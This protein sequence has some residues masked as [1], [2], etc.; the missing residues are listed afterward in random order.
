MYQIHRKVLAI[1]F[2]VLVAIASIYV[3][4]FVRTEH[5]QQREQFISATYSAAQ[6]E[7]AVYRNIATAWKA[8]TTWTPAWLSLRVPTLKDVAILDNPLFQ[9]SEPSKPIQQQAD[10]KE[11]KQRQMKTATFFKQCQQQQ[12]LW[13]SSSLSHRRKQHHSQDEEIVVH[14]DI[15]PIASFVVNQQLASVNSW[16]GCR[17]VTTKL[18]R[19][20][21]HNMFVQLYGR[22]E[23]LLVKSSVA[24]K[25]H[26]YT[27]SSYLHP[28]LSNAEILPSNISIQRV[29][30]SPGDVL[31]L[32]PLT[33]H[34][35]KVLDH[36]SI[37]INVWSRSKEEQ[38]MDEISY[39]IALPFEERWKASNLRLCAAFLY[40]SAILSMSEIQP[41]MNLQYWLE[42]RWPTSV[43]TKKMLHRLRTVLK[44][45]S[46]KKFQ[47]KF[48]H[49][50]ADVY[51]AVTTNISRKHHRSIL[52]L[53]FCDEVITFA[54]RDCSRDFEDLYD[55]D[56]DN[57]TRT[58]KT[59]IHTDTDTNKIHDLRDIIGQALAS[60]VKLENKYSGTTV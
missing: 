41:Q 32:P 49:R 25:M 46:L 11:I 31:Y 24:L 30:L 29:V 18:H 57:D 34:Q 50:A 48:Q 23:F 33:F 58:N 39:N 28:L 37:S 60:F 13:H 38:T 27:T 5:E 9:Y 59:D 8:Q 21:S 42:H 2:A 55:N 45:G 56:N 10:Q 43:S 40:L 1:T 12:Y 3:M 17:H 53:N 22:K 51:N 19:D 20:F 44:A 14:D 7:I 54:C 52:L 6:G 4:I 47:N 16:M 36:T 15:L 26:P 35:V